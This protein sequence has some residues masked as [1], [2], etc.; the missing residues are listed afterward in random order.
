M[1]TARPSLTRIRDASL[2]GALGGLGA[3]LVFATA[4]AFIIVP[5]WTRMFGGLFGASVV[6]AIVGWSYLELMGDDAR[7]R[8]T[9]MMRG[10]LF[11]A[12]LWLSIT[13]VTLLD[14]AFLRTRNLGEYTEDAIA[15]TI[16]ALAGG[17]WGWVR[18]RRWRAALA[19]AAGCVALAMA[20]GGPV[21]IRNS[22]WALGIWLAV[23][24][25]SVVAGGVL[26]M[27]LSLI[28]RRTAVMAP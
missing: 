10:A 27:T 7:P 15:V 13:P 12:L 6:G 16:A 14:A 25:A 21:P 20:M 17:L 28:R 26:G 19:G 22:R 18:T 8:A 1:V 11:G 24:P 3:G 2:A 9:E 5:I 23:L 4:H